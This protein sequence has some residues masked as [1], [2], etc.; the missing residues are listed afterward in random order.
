M[1]STW[2]RI[3]RVRS[4]RRR[5][6]GS[7]PTTVTPAHGTIAPGAVISKGKTPAPPTISFPSRHACIR[8]GGSIFEKRS[9]S[10]SPGTQPK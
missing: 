1:S 7:T 9:T 2:A 5:C 6:V 4:P 8:S 10:S 3:M